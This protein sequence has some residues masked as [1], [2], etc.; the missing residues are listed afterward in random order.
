MALEFLLHILTSSGIN[1]HFTLRIDIWDWIGGERHVVYC[2]YRMGSELDNINLHIDAF[3]SSKEIAGDSL[4]LH[5][6]MQFST[7]DGDNDNR[8]GD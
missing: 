4:S 1:R 3:V 7:R 8:A 5:N 6:R 2:C